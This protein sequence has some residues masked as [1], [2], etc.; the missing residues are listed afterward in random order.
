VELPRLEE[1]PK[2]LANAINEVEG[3]EAEHKE[4]KARQSAEWKK[5]R[6]KITSLAGQM[7]PL[8]RYVT[9][10]AGRGSRLPDGD[11]DERRG[12]RVDTLGDLEQGQRVRQVAAYAPDPDGIL[13]LGGVVQHLVGPRPTGQRLQQALVGV[14]RQPDADHGEPRIGL[15]PDFANNLLPGVVRYHAAGEGAMVENTDHT[16]PVGK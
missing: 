10:R 16:P 6:A 7:R 15:A 8:G 12:F 9:V 4:V 14:G 11:A 3:L 13:H 1:A 2:N 5:P